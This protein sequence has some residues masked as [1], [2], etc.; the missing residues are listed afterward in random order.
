[1]AVK[2]NVNVIIG[3]RMYTLSGYE[4]KEYLEQVAS[5]L[6]NKI[7]EEKSLDYYNK[8]SQDMRTVL[9]ELNIANDYFKARDHVVSNEENMKHKDQEITNLKHELVANQLETKDLK[10]QIASMQ[11]EIREL[12]LNKT[13]LEASLED[14]L[15]GVNPGKNSG[16]KEESGD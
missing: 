9:L 14:A 4:E 7:D 16:K 3:D 11:S 12:R 5:Y 13:R 8:L 2:N 15:L 6:N 1:M 10:E